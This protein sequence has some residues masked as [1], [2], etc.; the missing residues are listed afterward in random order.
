MGYVHGK[1]W[2]EKEIEDRIMQIVNDMGMKTFPTLT[3]MTEYYG[4]QGLRNKVSK[5]G[6][7]FVW[8]KKLGLPMKQSETCFGRK[9][10]LYA[11]KD[12]YEHTSR[13]RSEKMSTNHPYDLLVE[14]C[15][16]VD[17]KASHP[18]GHLLNGNRYSFNIEKRYPTCDIFL[19]YGLGPDNQILKTF[20]I[21]SFFVCGTT[22]IMLGQTRNGMRFLIIGTS[23]PST[24]G[25]IK[26]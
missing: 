21:P 11:I 18:V 2:D 14:G 25:F 17:V 22:Q 12:I 7:S 15:V 26:A 10:E 5:T 4:N 13:M 8:S 24:Q 20:I 19:L 9:Y 16:K 23:F 1:R 3:E 6:G